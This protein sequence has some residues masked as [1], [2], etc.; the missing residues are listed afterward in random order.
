MLKKIDTYTITLPQLIEEVDYHDF[1]YLEHVLKKMVHGSIVVEE[2]GFSPKRIKYCA[3]V[4]SSLN[5]PSDEV[6]CDLLKTADI[7][8]LNTEKYN[9]E[10]KV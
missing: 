10:S 9:L 4:Y 5:M 7:T 6:I 1:P 2:I 3:V 8:D